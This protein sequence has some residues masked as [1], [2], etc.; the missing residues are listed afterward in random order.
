MQKQVK[1]QGNA[2]KPASIRAKTFLQ[3]AVVPWE[4]TNSWTNVA[5][6]L[7]YTLPRLAGYSISKYDLCGKNAQNQNFDFHASQKRD[8]SVSVKIL[9]IMWNILFNSSFLISS[10][11]TV[12]PRHPYFHFHGKQGVDL[13]IPNLGAVTQLQ[14]KAAL[15]DH[16]WI[17]ADQIPCS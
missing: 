4:I 12:F 9:K 16:P 7:K 1:G 8:F 5:C 10:Y 14:R 6:N 2:T 13:G 15:E 3:F 11:C 17:S